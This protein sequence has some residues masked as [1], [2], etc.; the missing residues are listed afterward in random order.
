[1]FDIGRICVKVAGRDAGQKCIIVQKLEQNG[2]VLIDGQTRRRKCNVK[3]LEPTTEKVDI[4]E[5][6]T[7]E[8]VKATFAKL[9]IELRDTKPKSAADKPKKSK[10]KKEVPA[11]KAPKKEAKK[12]ETPKAE[13][14]KEELDVE[15]KAPEQKTE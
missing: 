12:V 13:E 4:K 2:L 10:A 7:H 5:N 8:E 14:K 11:K 3:H 6:A 1:M 15:E 9:N